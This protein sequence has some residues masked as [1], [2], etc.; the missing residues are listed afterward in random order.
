[1]P[2]FI[3]LISLS[4]RQVGFVSAFEEAA[5]KSPRKPLAANVLAPS[6]QQSSITIP[7]S[8]EESPFT[9]VPAGRTLRPR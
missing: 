5:P 8:A 2:S 3:Q 9:R 7:G 1:V 6:P 4:S